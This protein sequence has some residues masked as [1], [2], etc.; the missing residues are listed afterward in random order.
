MEVKMDKIRSGF[1]KQIAE[2]NRNWASEVIHYYQQQKNSQTKEDHI[3]HDIYLRLKDSIMRLIPKI[4][5]YRYLMHFLTCYYEENLKKLDPNKSF[6]EWIQKAYEDAGLSMPRGKNNSGNIHLVK[7][8]AEW[9][10]EDFKNKGY[11]GSYKNTDTKRIYSKID[12]SEAVWDETTFRGL[13]RKSDIQISR[14]TML[15][16]ALALDMG[17]SDLEV[18]LCRALE[19]TKL[20]IWDPTEFLLYI[21]FNYDVMG[22]KWD[23]YLKAK[24]L[25]DSVETKNITD[26]VPQDKIESEKNTTRIFTELDFLLENIGDITIESLY[27]KKDL[28]ITVFEKYKHIIGAENDYERT[29]LREFKAVNDI[30]C[31]YFGYESIATVWEWIFNVS[32]GEILDNVQTPLSEEERM[33]IQDLFKGN[34]FPRADIEYVFK[35]GKIETLT[36]GKMVTLFFLEFVVDVIEMEQQNGEYY[37]D[38]GEVEAQSDYIQWMNEKLKNCGFGPYNMNNGYENLLMKLAIS[39]NAFENF[40]FLCSY[41]DRARG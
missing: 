41:Y 32:E 30:L 33:V 29:I 15:I 26:Q 25:F 3:N 37:L 13:I 1:T 8:Y 20:N 11:L 14:E 21:T 39:N 16:L 24:E 22:S 34:I 7:Q 4:P 36:R 31:D 10:F 12:Q 2:E 17:G 35:N 6:E 23:F 27:H 40:Q 19:Q 38:R 28:W 9:M 5:T 18:F